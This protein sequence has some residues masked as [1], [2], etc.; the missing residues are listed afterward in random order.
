[1][2]ADGYRAQ[3]RQA[4]TVYSRKPGW[5]ERTAA[6]SVQQLGVCSSSE[7]RSAVASVSRAS[8]PRKASGSE[9]QSQLSTAQTS[10]QL[11]QPHSSASSEL[12]RTWFEMLPSVFVCADTLG[13]E[14]LDLARWVFNSLFRTQSFW[15]SRWA[16]VDASW[17]RLE[18]GA[19]RVSRMGQ[20]GTHHSS[21][22]GDRPRLVGGLRFGE[23]QQLPC[24]HSQ[25]G[26]TRTYK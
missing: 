20:M 15:S 23:F 25:P 10:C 1:M 7:Q 3:G 2:S 17:P 22:S 19:N 11:R 14:P 9:Q 26:R 8:R 24:N 5:C 16:Q 12:V 21:Q 18:R 4:D 13:P 6:R